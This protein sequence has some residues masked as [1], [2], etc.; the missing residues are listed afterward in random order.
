MVRYFHHFIT[1]KAVFQMRVIRTLT[2]FL[3]FA[4]L[5][6]V[7]LF[8]SGVR[9]ATAQE[10]GA[11]KKDKKSQAKPADADKK[12]AKKKTPA[13]LKEAGAA[14]A[15]KPLA[16]GARKYILTQHAARMGEE[17]YS[18]SIGEDKKIRATAEIKIQSVASVDMLQ[19]YTLEPGGT[20]ASYS[21][22]A[23]MM[24][25]KQ[26]LDCVYA[27][28]EIRAK[29]YQNG[30]VENISIR[31]SGPLYLLDNTNA[32]NY[33]HIID[34]YSHKN[35]GVQAFKVLVAQKLTLMDIEVDNRGFVKGFMAGKNAEYTEYAA[36][37]KS[38][39]LE[40][41][42]YADKGG[43]VAAVM[44]PAQKFTA[45]VEGFELDKTARPPETRDYVAGP[46]KVK[47]NGV[48]FKNK[49]GLKL[50]SKLTVPAVPS[51]AA[52]EASPMRAALIIAGSGPADR[53]GNSPLLNGSV[54]NLRDIAE[55]LAAHGIVSLRYD[56]RNIGSSDSTGDSP[57]SEYVSDAVSAVDF[58]CSK[59]GV[60][61]G[62]VYLIGHSEGALIA[63]SAAAASKKVKGVIL[64]AA[65]FTA[66]DKLIMEQV[67]YN[68][69][70]SVSISASDKHEFIKQLADAMKQL[71]KGQTP[72]I[73]EAASVPSMD[74]IIKSLAGQPK[75]VGE[76]LNIV[77]AKLAASLKVPVLLI[78]AGLDAQ[79]PVSDFTQYCEFFE[80]NKIGFHKLMVEGVNHVFKP[81]GAKN[82]PG[83][84]TS[85]AKVASAALN[86]IS[87]FIMGRLGR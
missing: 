15:S 56:K 47:E 17:T 71:K 50:Y 51:G 19:K 85:D 10:T 1:N 32:N 36:V 76:Y 86:A 23:Q 34:A 87:S 25:E 28:D 73:K 65:P 48:Y 39:G 68:L 81:A 9:G 58:L 64:M 80:K 66:F 21:L 8:D 30:T 60:D 62:G 12:T 45:A 49:S 24:G 77:P 37:E 70:Y 35:G 55:H 78:G 59:E 31:T 20:L 18:Y 40:I 2:L 11:G 53:D 14:A 43:A 57:F 27:D 69:E 6:C 63:M 42:I 84:Y 67:K 3:I 41:F 38:A 46:Y 26:K 29:V 5:S 52:G 33:Q 79:V 83:S 22:E 13:G 44:V 74:L 82:D 75:F 54:N 61:T 16:A 7:F 4:F 72:K